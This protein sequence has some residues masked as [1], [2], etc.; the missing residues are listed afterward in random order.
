MSGS[1]IQ[2]LPDHIANQIAAGEVIQRPA[3]VVKELIENAIDAGASKIDLIVKDA[4]RTLIQVVDNG[5]G[6]SEADSIMCFERHAT[7]KLHTAD[8][9]FHLRTKGFRGEALASIAAIAHVSL[10]TKQANSEVGNCIEIEGSEITKNEPVACSNGS[11][12]EVKN[13]FFNV[14]ARRNFLKSDSIEFKHILQEFERVVIPHFSLHFK[15]YHNGELIRDLPPANLRKR[16]VD[17]LGKNF[18]DKLVPVEEN[19]DIVKIQGFLIKPEACKKSRGDQYLF[20]NDR[21]F[22]DHYFHSAISKAYTNLLS[23][24]LIPGYFLFFEINPEKIDVNVHPTKTEIK[25]EEDRSIYQILL[26]ASKSSLG[27]FNI[28]PTLDFERETSFDVPNEMLST[29]P[30]EPLVKV[31]PNFNPFEETSKHQ[32]SSGNY[33]S[34]KSKA[35]EKAGFGIAPQEDWSQFYQIQ[36]EEVSEEFNN[37]ETPTL[38]LEIDTK[39]SDYLIAGNYLFSKTKNGI[40]SVHF[41]RAYERI[42]YDE[43]MQS[44]YHAP[45]MGQGLLFPYAFE[46]DSKTILLWEQNVKILNQLGFAFEINESNIELTSLPSILQEENV[47]QFLLELNGQLSDDSI[48]KGEIAHICILTISKA[49]ANQKSLITDN[50]GAQHLIEQLFACNDHQYSPNGKKILRKITFEQIETIN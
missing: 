41:R 37:A 35:L 42:V 8:D 33:G 15:I 43:L 6:M 29:T 31:N 14:P 44:F 9:L 10:K 49:S 11:S 38:D 39:K 7:S 22:K 45:I 46:A 36:E 4:G 17:L 20:V 16:L 23:Q 40:L 2:L 34:S 30:R 26:T 13:L 18:N 19:T 25:F 50:E 21:F 48:D 32:V 27:R 5:K 1:V 47:A 24:G 3:S 12:L 28:M